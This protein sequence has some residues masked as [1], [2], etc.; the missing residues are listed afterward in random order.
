MLHRKFRGCSHFSLFT[1]AQ[2]NREQISNGCMSENSGM[3]YNAM[4]CYI[5]IDL[6]ICIKVFLL[7][8]AK[9]RPLSP[10]RPASRSW[11]MGVSN[12]SER[13]PAYSS[14]AP[15]RC[16][17]PRYWQLGSTPHSRVAFEVGICKPMLCG[18][19]ALRTIGR[20]NSDT[21][22]GSEE[23]VIGDTVEKAL[24]IRVNGFK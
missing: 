6:P 23:S 16:T 13:S 10:T 15:S 14:S 17:L 7:H 9:S 3:C 21:R 22:G 12:H 1:G 8:P 24:Q 18:V 5:T 4:L 11:N 20:N 19:K 2:L